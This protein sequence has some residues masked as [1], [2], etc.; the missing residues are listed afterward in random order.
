M[1][2]SRPHGSRRLV[3]FCGFDAPSAAG[4]RDFLA[5]F[6]SVMQRY[7]KFLIPANFSATFFQKSAQKGRFFASEASKL[8]RCCAL[9]SQAFLDNQ[10]ELS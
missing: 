6:A 1:C 3:C 8:E 4:I 5:G 10:E 2:V 9:T 7:E